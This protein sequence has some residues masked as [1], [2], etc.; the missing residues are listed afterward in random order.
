MENIHD[1]MEVA[2][3]IQDALAQP[4]G[5]TEIDEDELEDELAALEIE[6]EN[7][8]RDRKIADLN[9]QLRKWAPTA[10]SAINCKF[11]FLFV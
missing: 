7:E 3:E 10:D 2:R 6:F 8:E 9:L 4:L 1:E 11:H 5:M